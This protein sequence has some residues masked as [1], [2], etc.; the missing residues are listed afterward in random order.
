MV[1][2]WRGSSLIQ[3]WRHVC[4]SV[5]T[6]PCYLPERTAR[7]NPVFLRLRLR[8]ISWATH[9]WYSISR[10]GYPLVWRLVARR[11]VLVFFLTA[12]RS[13][14]RIA[15]ST[16]PLAFLWWSWVLSIDWLSSIWIITRVL[17]WISGALRPTKVHR[18]VRTR[19][20]AT[21]STLNSLD[22]FNSMLK[23]DLKLRHPC[24]HLLLLQGAFF[25]LFL[26]FFK[27]I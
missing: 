15:S 9:W 16:W 23:F 1:L 24:F 7:W 20:V 11:K 18:A 22:P 12:C 5:R 19:T 25:M 21:S 6:D 4:I 3:P 2:I 17:A 10:S 8:P 14:I 13:R 27:L 26:N